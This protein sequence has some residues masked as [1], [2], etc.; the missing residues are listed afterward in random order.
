M[1]ASVA[2]GTVALHLTVSHQSD[3]G[4]S[5]FLSVQNRK[6]AV[7]AEWIIVF[8]LLLFLF[9]GIAQLGFIMNAKNT[10]T[11]AAYSTARVLLTRGNP[12]HFGQNLEEE[13]RK[14]AALV[15]IG[16]TG[17][18]NVTPYLPSSDP[19]IIHI[20]SRY[21]QDERSHADF[22]QRYSAALDKTR[23]NILEIREVNDLIKVKVEV[24]YDYELD[25][26]IVNQ[27]IARVFSEFSRYG[28]PHITLRSTVSL[29]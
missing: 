13:G 7:L 10:V 3:T 18:E 5:M 17:M 6:G 25:F 19:D 4:I 14:S 8:P 11:Y 16:I 22:L 26:P 24:L 27:F 12:A 21:D 15:C 28:Y 1:Y 23:L 29:G 9:L 2:F 20:A